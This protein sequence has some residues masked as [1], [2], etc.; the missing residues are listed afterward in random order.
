MRGAGEARALPCLAVQFCNGHLQHCK[1]LIS[2]PARDVANLPF[3]RQR[4]RNQGPSV[5]PLSMDQKHPP[6]GRLHYSHV[7]D[8]V[9]ILPWQEH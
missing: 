6:R 4:A 8:Y 1:P 2:A 7:S 3:V 5:R 9:R